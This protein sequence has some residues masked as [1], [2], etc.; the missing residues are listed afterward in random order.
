[1]HTTSPLGTIQIECSDNHITQLMILE[2][3]EAP[4]IPA[5]SPQQQV[6][7]DEIACYF[8]NPF[9][10]FHLSLNPSGTPFQLRVWEALR[11]IPAGHT[12]TYG[13]LAKQLK[14]SPRAVGQACRNNPI[15]I[16]IPCHRVVAVNHLG[17]YA[18]TTS[19][20]LM[21]IKKWLL[22]HEQS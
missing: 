13:E 19:G 22:C 7:I 18:G 17:G 5:S 1:M 14:S 11:H 6:I 9:H 16:I 4:A 20:R 12:L 2:K 10:I 21:D 8:S 15:P 3:S